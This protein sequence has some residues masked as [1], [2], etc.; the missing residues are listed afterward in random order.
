MT[1]EPKKR[2]EPT[3]T[4]SWGTADPSLRDEIKEARVPRKRDPNEIIK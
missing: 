3:N 1:D 2:Q 4:T